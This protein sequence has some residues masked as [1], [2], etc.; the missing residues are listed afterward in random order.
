VAHALG[1]AKTIFLTDV[2]GWLSDADD[3]ASLIS[4]TNAA[5][6][7]RA[8]PTIEG[9]MRPKLQACLA[10]LRGG[11]LTASIVDGRVEHSI[12]LE[13]FTDEGFGTQVTVEQ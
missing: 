10:A 4:Q 3:P 13:L 7:E 8:L 12:L 9:G 6:V 11:G 2:A 1:A 5:E